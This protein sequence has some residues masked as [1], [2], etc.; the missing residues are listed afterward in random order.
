[1]T[2]WNIH[3]SAQQEHDELLYYFGG[4]DEELVTAFEWHYLQYRHA[5]CENPLFCNIRRK[6][7]RRANLNPRFGEYD[8]A[9]LIWRQKVVI[10]A[11]AHAKRRPYYWRKRIDEAKKL[12]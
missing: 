10:L 9:Y 12:F 11:V 6:A 5:I 2:E 8:I 3:P 1:M 4:I 7:V